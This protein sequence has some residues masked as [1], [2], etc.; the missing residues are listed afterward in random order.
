MCFVSEAQQDDDVHAGSVGPQLTC[1]ASSRDGL[2]GA[3]PAHPPPLHPT[4]HDCPGS[5]AQGGGQVASVGGGLCSTVTARPSLGPE[6]R[7]EKGPPQ[8]QITIS[9]PASSTSVSRVASRQGPHPP[10][11]PGSRSQ[12]R[13]R[14]EAA[15][16]WGSPVC[17]GLGLQSG[18]E[19]RLTSASPA[20]S[21]HFHLAPDLEN[22]VAPLSE[23]DA[24]PQP[25]L[26]KVCTSSFCF[27]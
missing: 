21:L 9:P 2:L 16:L 25:P 17:C 13:P 14:V 12:T 7:Y 15:I 11:R 27:P 20:R 1:E 3:S 22:Y 26:F 18:G 5:S 6:R 19:G 24:C 4:L 23:K 10:P 8:A